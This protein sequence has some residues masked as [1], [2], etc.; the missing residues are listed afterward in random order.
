MQ[1][2]PFKLFPVP[3]AVA[4]LAHPAFASEKI[5]FAHLFED[6]P[7]IILGKGSIFRF[8]IPIAQP[9]GERV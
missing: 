7:L 1:P 4:V 3:L 8:I 2:S 5:L 9:I 6:L